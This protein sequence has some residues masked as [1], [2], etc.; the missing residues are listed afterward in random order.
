M[1][2]IVA[3]I[4]MAWWRMTRMNERADP[5][6]ADAAREGTKHPVAAVTTLT[7]AY[8]IFGAWTFLAWY[9][10]HRRGPYKWGGDGWFGRNTY[11]GGADKLGHAWG[12]MTLARLG[13]FL[14]HR[15]G[16][17]DRKK[18]AIVSASASELLFLGIE[19]KDGFYYEFSFSDL[20][21]NTCGALA[22]W[23]LD[24]FPRLDELFA[25][26][27]DYFPSEMYLRQLRGDSP[28][29]PSSCSRWNVAEDYSGET[30]LTAFHLGGVRALRERLGMWTRFVDV[31]VGF[32]T[33]GY[34]PLPDLDLLDNAQQDLSVG[35]A[36]NAQ[37]FCDW[38]LADSVW[39]K[40][41]TA[42]H[43]VFAV[44]QM[45]FTFQPLSRW[46]RE[47]SL[48]QRRG[49]E[50]FPPIKPRAGVRARGPARA[51]PRRSMRARSPVWRRVAPPARSSGA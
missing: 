44:F 30:F 22:A 6:R 3:L 42:L 14:L 9:R 25:F 33:R 16:G 51:I 19:V 40:T 47:R 20:T 37:G 38:M 26:R 17:F 36:F 35:L 50:A 27:V 43:G 45:P 7:T 39:R 18:S 32:G 29:P 46:S 15:W 31:G 23:A 4:A 28:C 48:P 11:A 13:T 1:L 2:L 24:T 21:G 5:S 12:A 49:Y 34:K 8:A 41:R 10:K